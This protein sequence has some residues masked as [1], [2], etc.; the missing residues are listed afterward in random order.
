MVADER[1]LVFVNE[2][3]DIDGS[4]YAR[5]AEEGAVVSVGRPMWDR[6]GQPMSVDE[7]IESCR[8]AVAVMGASRDYFT[9]EFM[10]ACKRLRVISKYGIGTE[11]IDIE[12]ATELGIMVGHTPVPENYNSVA[13]HAVALMLAV[14]RRIGALDRHVREGGWRGPDTRVESL[15]GQTIG[16]V[17]LGRIGKNVARRLSGWGV[18]LIAFDPYV[19]SDDAVPLDVELVSLDVLLER[20]SV[21]TLHTLVSDETRKMIDRRALERVRPGTI[22]VNTARGEL[23]DEDALVEA[24][25]AGRIAGAGLDVTDPEPPRPGSDLLGFDQVVL[26]P[27]VSSIS[28]RAIRAIVDCAAENTVAVLRGGHPKYLRNPEVLSRLR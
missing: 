16:I 10:Q 9:R 24:L 25:H 8:D 20:A 17:G 27:H 5:L 28:D 3:L 18:E 4:S 15:E 21:I 1:P 26:S 11:K 6:P 19:S 7:M 22:L 13:E 2:E 12:S 14:L 23:V